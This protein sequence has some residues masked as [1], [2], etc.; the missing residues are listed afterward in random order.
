MK[1]KNDILY[2]NISTNIKS[3]CAWMKKC[4]VFTCHWVVALLSFAT[5]QRDIFDTVTDISALTSIVTASNGFRTNVISLN[6]CHSSVVRHSTGFIRTV[7]VA[8]SG[9]CTA[10]I[11]WHICRV[12]F[13]CVTTSFFSFRVCWLGLIS[14]CN[15]SRFAAVTVLWWSM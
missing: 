7:I 10:H 5:R 9:S 8:L 12:E 1:T 3:I 6:A 14:S 11:L 4:I 2:P 13:H 15:S